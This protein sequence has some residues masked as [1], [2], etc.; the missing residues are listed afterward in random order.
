MKQR[1]LTIAWGVTVLSGM[2]A[3]TR[4]AGRV[5]VTRTL[6]ANS[7]VA[8]TSMLQPHSVYLFINPACPCSR[9]S[10]INFERLRVSNRD[11]NFYLV[12]VQRE[13]YRA[14][15]I[16]GSLPF[17]DATTEATVVNDPGEISESLAA[18]TSG[19]VIVVDDQ[20]QILFN[21][22]IT[23]ARGHQGDCRGMLLVQQILRGESRSV[24][25]SPVFG[26]ALKVNRQESL[27][28]VK[29]L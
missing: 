10:Q 16:P 27:P 1:M 3:V 5:D 4:H 22:G 24:E 8:D 17:F 21:G 25:K 15:E 2:I 7:S 28:K 11:W 14:S 9:S 6:T 18:H 19:Q 23:P 20:M 13:N 29:T 26:C 12:V